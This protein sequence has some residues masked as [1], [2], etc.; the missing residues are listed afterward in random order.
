LALHAI[1]VA[2]ETLCSENM[3]LYVADIAFELMLD[4][5]S[6][7]NLFLSNERKQ[8]IILRVKERR[9]I[10]ADIVYHLQNP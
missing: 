6:K 10:Y 4:E 8:E 9:T 5:L 7:Q 2:V 3:N 1:K